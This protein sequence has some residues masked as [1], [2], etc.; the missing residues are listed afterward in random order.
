MQK[1]NAE[2]QDHSYNKPDRVVYWSWK[3]FFSSSIEYIKKYMVDK[4][5]KTL[6]KT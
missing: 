3:C 4:L 2:K 6:R 5:Q 1:I